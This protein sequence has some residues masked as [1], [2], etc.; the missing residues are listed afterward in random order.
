MRQP[1]NP[2]EDELILQ[3]ELLRCTMLLVARRME[4]T[5][6]SAGPYLRLIETMNVCSAILNAIASHIGN[7]ES[8]AT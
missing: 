3:I 7:M 4:A 5:T 8:G 2:L 1:R 6:R